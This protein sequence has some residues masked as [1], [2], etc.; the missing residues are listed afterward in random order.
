MK[1]LSIANTKQNGHTRTPS[2]P[3]FLAFN[4]IS[5]ILLRACYPWE[6]VL[7]LRTLLLTLVSPYLEALSSG[8]SPPPSAFRVI[9]TRT[10]GFVFFLFFSFLFFLSQTSREGCVWS[11]KFLR[12]PHGIR[13]FSSAFDPSFLSVDREPRRFLWNTTLREECKREKRASLFLVYSTT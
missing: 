1:C 7:A 11:S 9:F 12:C 3:A 10:S 4:R 2:L 8:R 6:N 5:S 13:G